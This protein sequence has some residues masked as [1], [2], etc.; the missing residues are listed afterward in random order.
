MELVAG[1]DET[2]SETQTSD[3]WTYCV[4]TDDAAQHLVADHANILARGT[5]K[6][7]HGKKFKAHLAQEYRDFLSAIRLRSENAARRLLALKLM[8]ETWKTE[9][10]PFI[11]R[12]TANAIAAVGLA[13]PSALAA[14]NRIMPA[15]AELQRLL[16]DV[17]SSEV[18]SLE[19]DRDSVTKKLPTLTFSRGATEASAEKVLRGL[20]AG[21]AKKNH[22]DAPALSPA[23]VRIVSD[24]NSVIVQAADV[25]GNFALAHASSVIGHGSK[26]LALKSKIFADIF[27]D[28]L[29]G[30]SAAAEIALSSNN[31]LQIAQS[32]AFGVLMT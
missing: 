14:I 5:V 18:I 32:G 29:T 13:N 7:F 30:T 28:D 16:R 3:G 4:L 17:G 25:F 2:A 11:H 27:G 12:V 24:T 9:F 8:D 22:P 26:K 1:I 10:V 20:Y 21:F 15:I 31:E 23:G 19:I 6:S